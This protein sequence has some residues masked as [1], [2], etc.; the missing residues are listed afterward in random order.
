MLDDEIISQTF[1]NTMDFCSPR[2][3]KTQIIARNNQI[4]Y[5]KTFYYIYAVSNDQMKMDE[6]CAIPF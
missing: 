5:K 2:I 6:R 1:T 4:T 3:F